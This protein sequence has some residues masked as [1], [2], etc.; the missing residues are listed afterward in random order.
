VSVRATNQLSAPRR[1]GVRVDL[2]LAVLVLVVTGPV[3]REWGAQQASRI[4]LTA[5]IWDDH[6]VRIDGYPLGADRAVRDGHT[7]SDKAPGQPFFAVPAY[8]VY[9]AL[10]GEPAREK[11]VEGNLGLWSASVWSCSIPLALLAIVI[12][13]AAAR[14][15][16]VLA[17]KVAVAITFGSLLLPFGTVLFGHVLATL[18]AFG[19][20]Y[21][22]TRAHPRGRDLFA[23]G[24]LLGAAVLVEYTMVFAAAATGAHV[25]WVHR[26]R[27]GAVLLGAAPSV[28]CLLAYQQVAFGSPFRFSYASSTFAEEARRRGVEAASLPLVERATRALVGERGLFVVSCVVAVAA[29]GMVIAIREARGARRSAMVAA[30]VAATS[31]TVVQMLWSSPTGGSGPGPRYA[32][33]AAAF[34]TPGLVVAWRRWPRVCT[35]AAVV[36]IGVMLSASWTYPLIQRDV[37]DAIARWTRWLS[38]GDWTETL[39]TIRFGERASVLL[40]G[41]SLV[42][43][44]HL[45]VHSRRDALATAEHRSE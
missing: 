16:P 45:A 21:L 13:R 19:G 9:R 32:T 10:G 41:F 35:A 36:S 28:V 14:D 34:L 40:V 44:A 6:S 33:A 39:F 42:A 24:L 4:A 3:V 38:E 22:A 11:R 23:S 30:G 5:A 31:V 1:Y 25:A 27:V 2:A 20:W 12:R 8:A 7:Y 37:T 18:C 26:R 29:V 17:P 43:A 15:D